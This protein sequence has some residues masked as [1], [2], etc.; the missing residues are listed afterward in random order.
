MEV[1]FA[2]IFKLFQLKDVNVIEKVKII[3]AHIGIGLC[4][5][6]LLSQKK[7]QKA[8]LAFCCFG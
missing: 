6:K 5:N 2:S 8:D 3:V 1:V 7:Q 4:G